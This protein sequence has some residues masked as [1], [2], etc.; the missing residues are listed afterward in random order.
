MSDETKIGTLAGLPDG[1]PRAIADELADLY[2]GGAEVSVLHVVSAR[3]TGSDRVTSIVMAQ[4]PLS[5]IAIAL[6][7]RLGRVLYGADDVTRAALSIGIGTLNAL[8]A[9]DDAE[10][11]DDAPEQE[12]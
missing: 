6:G 12:D 7:R 4:G 9:P 5:D 8:Y 2:G 1:I 11:A 10:A 3:D